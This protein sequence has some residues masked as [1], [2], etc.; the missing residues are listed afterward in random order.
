VCDDGCAYDSPLF[1]RGDHL[2]PGPIVPRRFLEVL[3]SAPL[4]GS[5]SS[6]RLALAREITRRDNP[7]TARV[8]ANRVWQHLFGRGLVA[9]P[10]NFGRM[11]EKPTH[12]ELLDHLATRL[13]ADGWSVKSLIRY[14]VT[15]RTWQLSSTPPPGAEKIDPQNE[16]LSHAHVR[17]LTAEQI[18]DSMLAV[19]GNLHSGHTGPG[20]RGFYKTTID[21]DKQPAPGPI[22]GDGRRS[23]YLEVRRNFPH[24]FLATFDCPKPNT[25]TGRRSET[26][27]PAQSL[28]LL[29]DPFVLHQAKVW[30]ERCIADREEDRIAKMYRTAF[31]RP[32]TDAEIASAVAFLRSAETHPWPAFAHAIFNMKEFIYVR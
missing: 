18:R 2:Q 19:A 25:F 3:G 1:P 6:G 4:G 5:R 30:A 27:V 12:P 10:D 13:M 9:S 11:G 24:D 17:R 20:V 32:P 7:L 23:I 31:A 15:S 21:P 26:N 8:M 14:I 22:D 28:A 29:N 16:L